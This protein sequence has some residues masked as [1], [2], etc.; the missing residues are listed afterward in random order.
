MVE[1]FK[2]SQRVSPALRRDVVDFI[3]DDA[4]AASPAVR[5]SS[6]RIRKTQ[7]RLRRLV[8]DDAW[9]VYLDLE[10][11]ANERASRELRA[12]FRRLLAIYLHARA[13]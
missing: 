5:R 13:V 3:I 2:P 6:V 1:A 4:L 9:R 12:L 7:G 11:H 10:R 8:N